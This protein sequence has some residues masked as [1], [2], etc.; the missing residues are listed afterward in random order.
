MFYSVVNSGGNN[1][2]HGQVVPETLDLCCSFM[3]LAGLSNGEALDLSF[4][5]CYRRAAVPHCGWGVTSI[6]ARMS[7]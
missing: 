3:F 6:G 1:K 5:M 2:N 7:D 4:I